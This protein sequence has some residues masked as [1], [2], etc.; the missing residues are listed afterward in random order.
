MKYSYEKAFIY[1]LSVV[2]HFIWMSYC[3]GPSMEK[4][5]EWLKY[6]VNPK[7]ILDDQCI[8]GCYI[9]LNMFDSLSMLDIAHIVS[10]YALEYVVSQIENL[11]G[12]LLKSM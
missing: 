9:F 2:M 6:G 3:G 7:T 5:F 8:C 12:N 1:L 11:P 10:F 4:S